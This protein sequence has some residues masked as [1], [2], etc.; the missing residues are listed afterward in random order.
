M[1]NFPNYVLQMAEAFRQVMPEPPVV[2][3]ATSQSEAYAQWRK[4]VRAMTDVICENQVEVA[5]FRVL[6]GELLL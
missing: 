5:E 4:D 1:N 2:P 3:G 6:A